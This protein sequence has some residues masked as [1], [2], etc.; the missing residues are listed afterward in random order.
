[1]VV[2]VTKAR[3]NLFG[4]PWIVAFENK[5]GF[6]IVTSLNKAE[7]KDIVGKENEVFMVHDSKKSIEEE[8]K[9]KFSQVFE[10]GLGNCSK[11]KAHLHL[12]K[13][14]KPVFIRARPVPLGVKKSVEEEIDRLLNIGAIKPIEF[15]DWAAP[16]LAVR[17]QNGKIRVCIDYSTGSNEALELNKY[18][19]PTPQEIWSEIHGS[20]V[21]SQLDLR[22]AYL[23]VELDEASKKL[24]NINTHRGLFEVQRLPFGVKSAPAIFQKLMDELISGLEGVFAYLDDLIIVSKNEKDH[25]KTLLELF[26]RIQ[27]YNLKFS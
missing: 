4:L 22:D 26:G 18:P 9:A 7:P 1:M 23:Q 8:L 2:Y 20:K 21:F 24:T 27:N 19:L 5:L 10:P 12:K 16:I 14:T 13:G 3:M 6:P 25:K 17:K 11:I 15:A